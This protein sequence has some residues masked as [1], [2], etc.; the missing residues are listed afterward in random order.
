MTSSTSTPDIRRS[1]DPPSGSE[2]GRTVS[3][4]GGGHVGRSLVER[5]LADGADAR[6][7]DDTPKVVAAAAAAGVPVVDGDPT[8]PSTLDAAGLADADTVVAATTSDRANLLVAQL[9][10]ARFGVSAV[11]VRVNDPDH[12]ETFESLDYETVCVTENVGT[13]L[14]SRLR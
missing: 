1:S 8:D 13:A 2:H 12:V 3:V 4:V 11:V 7:V 10:R 6:L 14:A 9:A 5:L